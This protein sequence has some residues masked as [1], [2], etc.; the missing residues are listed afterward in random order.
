[1]FVDY[2][3]HANEEPYVPGTSLGPGRPLCRVLYPPSN[4]RKN[5]ARGWLNEC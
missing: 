1:M 3:K 5:V 2:A 4:I